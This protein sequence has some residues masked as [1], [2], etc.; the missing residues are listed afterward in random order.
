MVSQNYAQSISD[1]LEPTFETYLNQGWEMPPPDCDESIEDMNS[2]NQINPTENN[3]VKE[4]SDP[5]KENTNN[6]KK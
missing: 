5:P 3:L 1:L 2:S 4:V 6:E